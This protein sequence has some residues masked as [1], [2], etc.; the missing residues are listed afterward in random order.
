[1]YDKNKRPNIPSPPEPP[2]EPKT[3]LENLNNSPLNRNPLE[4]PVGLFNRST[5]PNVSLPA[6]QSGNG[7][8]VEFQVK[9]LKQRMPESIEPLYVVFDSYEGASSFSIDYRINAASL[10]ISVTI[11]LKMRVT[12]SDYPWITTSFLM[13][14]S[15]LLA[16]Q[17]HK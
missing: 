11:K 8:L 13:P 17:S 3:I 14:F 4:I 7:D 16:I 10:T 6:I 15:N 2:Q 12:I 1:L 5:Y 9:K